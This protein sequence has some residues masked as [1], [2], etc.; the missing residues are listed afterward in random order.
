[1]AST[2][3]SQFKRSMSE[4]NSLTAMCCFCCSISRAKRSAINFSCSSRFF[5]ASAAW[6]RCVPTPSAPVPACCSAA[7]DAAAAAVCFARSAFSFAHAVANMF[8]T[9]LGPGGRDSLIHGSLLMRR[10]ATLGVLKSVAID[11]AS[12]VD[13]CLIVAHAFFQ[14]A[15]ALLNSGVRFTTSGP[16]R[17]LRSPFLGDFQICISVAA[18]GASPSGELCSI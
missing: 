13:T 14:N 17:A 3:T 16:Q 15:C 11:R 12:V 5:S 4:I 10:D 1:M 18:L 2:S 7:A 8:T 9:V 6:R